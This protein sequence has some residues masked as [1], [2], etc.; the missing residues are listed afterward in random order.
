MPVRTFSPEETVL[1][2][3][4]VPIG[5]FTD[6][7]GIT[8]RRSSDS[9]TKKSGMKGVVSRAKTADKS[10]EIVI[11]LAQTSPSNDVLSALV[12]LD[13][14]QSTGVVP[15][16]VADLSGRSVYATAKAWIR[17]PAEG[18]FGKEISDRQWTLDC[19]DLFMFSGGNPDA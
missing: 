5:G 12:A 13:E 17:K 8:V 10:G 4:G 2:V 15:V 9:F 11:T 14:A 1:T 6:G 3:N 7:T 18:S 16:Q 19:A